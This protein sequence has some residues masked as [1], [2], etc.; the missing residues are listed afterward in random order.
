MMYLSAKYCMFD[1]EL[2]EHFSPSICSDKATKSYEYN[3]SENRGF[4][5]LKTGGSIFWK[6]SHMITEICHK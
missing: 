5:F 1:R 6:K 2:L 4:L 3:F